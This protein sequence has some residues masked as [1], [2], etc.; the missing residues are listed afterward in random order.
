MLSSPQNGKSRAGT[1]LIAYQ[2]LPTAHDAFP[3]IQNLGVE[4]HGMH[5]SSCDQAVKTNQQWGI[6]PVPIRYPPRISKKLLSYSTILH[7]LTHQ[8][9]E[10]SWT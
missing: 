7:S 6:L 8:I 9:V 4:Y 5:L 3:N 2:L 1:F 10:L